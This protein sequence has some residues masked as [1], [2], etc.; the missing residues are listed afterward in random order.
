MQHNE[1]VINTK[2]KKRLFLL[3]IVPVLFI[4]ILSSVVVQETLDEG[5]N[6]QLIKQQIQKAKIVGDIVHLMQYERGLA[7]GHLVDGDDYDTLERLNLT[8][9]KLKKVADTTKA[10]YE[11]DKNAKD[12]LEICSKIH[13]LRESEDFKNFSASQMRD[14]YTKNISMLLDFSRTIPAMLNDR[15]IRNYVQAYTYLS[16]N[17]ESLGV[18]RATLNEAMH[19][20]VLSYANHLIITQSFKIYQASRSRFLGTI[21]N[22]KDMIEFY[23]NTQQESI[24]QNVLDTIDDVIKANVLPSNIASKE[25]F[26]NISYAI[27]K[28]KDVEEGLFFAITTQ[29]EHKQDVLNRKIAFIVLFFITAAISFFI[30]IYFVAKRILELTSK[31]VA[32]KE[33]FKQIATTDILTS[34]ANRYS[35]N[36]DIASFD[37]PKIAIINIDGFRQINDFYGHSFGDEIVKKIAKKLN[38]FVKQNPRAKLYRLQGDEFALLCDSYDKDIFVSAILKILSIAKEK[39]VVDSEEIYLSFGCGIS[40]EDKKHLISSANMALKKSKND[41]KEI[42]IFS[43]EISLNKEYENNLMCAKRLSKA[44]KNSNIVP[45]FQPIVDNASLEIVKYEAL[46]RMRDE[47]MGIIAP[48]NFLRVAKQTR[49][50]FD[51]TKAMIEKSLALFSTKESICSINLSIKDILESD[52]VDFIFEKLKEHNMSSR[53]LFEIVESEY[54]DNFDAVSDFI[55]KS[56]AMGCKIA[57]DDFGTGY[58]NFEYLTRL[59]ID[60]LKIDGSLIKN[61]AKD[62]NKYLVVSTIVEFAK[63]M[64]VKTVAEFVEDE[65]TFDIVKSLGIDFSQGYHFS[66]PIEL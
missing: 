49:Q 24:F 65:E 63:K 6:L 25:L 17:K 55:K 39:I 11:R 10:M 54:I 35:L 46:V 28:L 44:L 56:K 40:F 38:D 66:K 33:E 30:A 47:Q 45:F 9:E 5:H 36:L 32:K 58:S 64:G 14:F 53:V 60:F 61:I 18:I 13:T 8:R 3:L 62:K 52:V 12:V 20:D 23:E 27:D 15:E 41:N 4:I 21:A 50:Y 57:I 22:S 2:I 7:V 26:D 19:K 42:V 43:E 51:I 16:S 48:Y 59:D 37:S 1:D 31:L 34:L 29:I